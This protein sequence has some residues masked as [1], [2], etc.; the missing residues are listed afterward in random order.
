MVFEPN[1]AFSLLLSRIKEYNPTSRKMGIGPHLRTFL[2][3]PT[4]QEVLGTGKDPAPQPSVPPINPESEIQVTLKSL[5]KA[6]QDIQKKLSN[7]PTLAKASS[8]AKCAGAITTQP[9][10]T[11]LAIAGSR[12]PNPSLVVDLVHLSIV[13]EDHH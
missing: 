3:D 10:K 5:S 1:G 12:P 4:I 13:N 7:P 11:Y 8:T 2:A 6:I 9:R